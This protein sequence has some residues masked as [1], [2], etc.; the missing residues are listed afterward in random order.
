MSL[1]LYSASCTL[2]AGCIHTL[3]GSKAVALH[4]AVWAKC[5]IAATNSLLLR[6]VT[7]TLAQSARE[8]RDHPLGSRLFTHAKSR[9]THRR[10]RVTPQCLPIEPGDRI[11][12]KPETGNCCPEPW[13][14]PVQSLKGGSS[15]ADPLPL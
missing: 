13:A 14:N 5:L 12:A 8:I 15:T 6:A 11:V 4:C 9:S 2:R 7:P 10:S 1:G 3:K